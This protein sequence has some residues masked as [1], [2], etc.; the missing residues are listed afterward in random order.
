[1]T[2]VY[3]MRAH[4]PQDTHRLDRGHDTAKRVGGTTQCPE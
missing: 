1:M 3:G 4:R 2:D